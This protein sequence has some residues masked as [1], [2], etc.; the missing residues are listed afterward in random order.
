MENEPYKRS[1]WASMNWP[2][3]EMGDLYA[4]DA[5]MTEY[6]IFN[7]YQGD[8]YQLTSGWADARK[9]W[10]E[11]LQKVGGGMAPRQAVKEFS[12]TVGKSTG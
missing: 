11:M 2:V 4:N 12:D 1:V 6:G 7:Q 3:R 9:A 5:L 10:W 8:Y